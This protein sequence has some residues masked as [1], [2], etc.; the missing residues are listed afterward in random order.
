MNDKIKNVPTYAKS[1]R[2]TRFENLWPGSF[3]TIVAEPSRNIRES[4]DVRVFQKAFDG[5]YAEHP[6][7]GVGVVLMPHDIVQ[8][9]RR[10]SNRAR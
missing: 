10:V 8:P 5:F 3:F 2:P 9:M 4:K 1:A 6:A 7:T